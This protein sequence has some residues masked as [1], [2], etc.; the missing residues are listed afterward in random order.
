M[1]A[2]TR[3]SLFTCSALSCHGCRPVVFYSTMPCL[4]SLHR[5]AFQ[6]RTGPVFANAHRAARPCHGKPSHDSY[7]CGCC[8]PDRESVVNRLDPK[9]LT[10]SEFVKPSASPKGKQMAT[11]ERTEAT[12]TTSLSLSLSLFLSLSLS[13]S[14]SL[15]CTCCST[16]PLSCFPVL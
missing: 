12:R 13:F 8:L 14:P 9:S 6:V 5:R 11:G 4:A 16:T 1:R 2:P 15:S 10:P 3:C 7:L